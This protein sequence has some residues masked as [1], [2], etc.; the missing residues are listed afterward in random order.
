L[1]PFISVYLREVGWVLIRVAHGLLIY[2]DEQLPT[3]A[4]AILIL[5]IFFVSFYFSLFT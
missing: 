2:I 1:F 3:P 4:I 5:D